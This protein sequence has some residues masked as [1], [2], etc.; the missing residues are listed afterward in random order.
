M[1]LPPRTL[2]E[3]PRIA[4]WRQD[5]APGAAENNEKALPPLEPPSAL[6]DAAEILQRLVHAPAA[7]DVKPSFARA[8]QPAALLSPPIGCR[9]TTSA[10]QPLAEPVPESS[11]VAPSVSVQTPRC[12]G[13]PRKQPAPLSVSTPC[14]RCP[15]L[16]RGDN[17]LCHSIV[18]TLLSFASPADPED[19]ERI[20]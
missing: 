13:R 7:S 1:P 9:S 6:R 12:C 4:N 8:S 2:S 10:L 17:Q 19:V 18:S 11:L 14:Q 5:G 20:N 16:T 3:A 15:P